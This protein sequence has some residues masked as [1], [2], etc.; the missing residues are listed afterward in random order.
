MTYYEYNLAHEY[1]RENVGGCGGCTY[2]I[3]KPWEMP[4][5]ICERNCMDLY[6]RDH[7]GENVGKVD[8]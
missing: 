1:E 3:R 7:Y 5:R 8:E 2:E 6:E 4:C